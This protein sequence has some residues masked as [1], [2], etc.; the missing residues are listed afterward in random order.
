MADRL[1][2]IS[3]SP[4]V[5]PILDQCRRDLVDS[6]LLALVR[7]VIFMSLVAAPFVAALLAG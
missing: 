1:A 3:S 2:R 6:T 5:V 7:V 4:R